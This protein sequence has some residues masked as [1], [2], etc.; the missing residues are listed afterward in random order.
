MPQSFRIRYRGQKGRIPKNFGLPSV[1]HTRHAV[2]HITAGEVRD[3]GPSEVQAPGGHTVEQDFI[4]NLGDAD[5]WVS[6][7]SPHGE[8]DHFQ[9]EEGG[10]EFI[11]HVDYGHPVDVGVTI[12]VDDEPPV[13]I[14]NDN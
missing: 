1:I 2:V 11:L 4:Y 7:I 10:V 12:C 6:N 9:G 3:G 13:F 8:N 5:V 14:D